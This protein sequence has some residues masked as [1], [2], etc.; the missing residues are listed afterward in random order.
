MAEYRS[1]PFT[2]VLADLRLAEP[3]TVEEEH[4]DIFGG[5]FRDKTCIDKELD[6]LIV[7]NVNCSGGCD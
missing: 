7:Q 4:R 2:Q 5:L 1:L 3:V 6:A